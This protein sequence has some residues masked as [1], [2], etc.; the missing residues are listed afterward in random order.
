[1]VCRNTIACVLAHCFII[2]LAL[3]IEWCK[4]RAREARWREEI[5]LLQEEKRRIL[6]FM[7][8]QADMWISHKHRRLHVADEVLEG[9]TA[10]AD[11]QASLRRRLGSHFNSLWMSKGPPSM[12]SQDQHAHATDCH[13]SAG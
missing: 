8:W 2:P 13:G 3:R 7:S 1:M 9:L 12:T 5:E 11:R 6:A 10:Y 4:A